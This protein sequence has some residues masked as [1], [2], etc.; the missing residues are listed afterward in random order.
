MKKE[1]RTKYLI[2]YAIASIAFLV[3]LPALRNEFV[4]WDDGLYVYEN[5]HIQ[6]A[7]MK[8]VQW[9]FFSFHAANW[10]P[11]TWL[12]HS[13]DYAVW[14]LNPLGHH[15]TNNVLHS[16]N[17]LM[18]VFL[19]KTLVEISQKKPGYGES[20]DFVPDGNRGLIVGGVSGLLFGIHPLHVESVAWIAER[21]DV[22]C[23]LFFL[24]SLRSYISFVI[25]RA[26]GRSSQGGT[27][28][29]FL[30]TRYLCALGCFALALLS[31]PMAVTLPLVLLIIDWYPCGRI[32]SPGTLRDAVVE[33]IPFFMLSV[34]SSILTILAQGSEKAIVPFQVKPL[35]ARIIMGA[36][37]LTSY[38][39]KMLLPVHLVPFYPN[40]DD[41]SFLS[42]KYLFHVL[43]VVAITAACFMVIKRQKVW[44]AVWSYY[45][46]TLLPVLG[47]IQVGGQSM[48]DRYAYLPSIGPFA[49]LG[50]GAAKAFEKVY[51]AHPRGRTMKCAFLIVGCMV[52]LLLSFKSV[53]QITIWRNSISL[54]SYV[55]HKEPD[56]MT[57][58]YYNLG[59][60][61]GRK[62]LLDIAIDSFSKAI[63]INPKFD[64]A[65]NNRGTAYYLRGQYDKAFGDFN[66]AINLNPNNA[67]A[68]INRGYVNF[69]RG[70]TA[71]AVSDLERGCYLGNEQGCRALRDIRKY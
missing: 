56:K 28:S 49:L 30:D 33:K 3:Y 67:E 9:A 42:L 70:D 29:R 21:K 6:S 71:F 32:Q 58:A 4:N 14:G 37:A 12:S 22:L 1:I 2:A 65:Y 61:Y 17:T 18:V 63:D 60:V 64:M 10:H 25:G 52:V 68:Y 69:R 40:P 46:I 35:T 44:L 54:W 36:D 66:E 39:S 45:V 5:P 8:L 62:G 55:I 34:L 13:M 51:S 27:V 26:D 20:S 38:L 19:V 16:L 41:I 57:P 50:V 59:L 11:L 15:L 24:L 43:L 7:S 48:A 47:I 23:A 53:R 31:K